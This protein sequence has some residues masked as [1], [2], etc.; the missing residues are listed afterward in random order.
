MGDT[1][2]RRARRLPRLFVFTVQRLRESLE[3][4]KAEH[5]QRLQEIA[6]AIGAL[7]EHPEVLGVLEKLSK[8]GY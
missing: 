8:L 6:E 3:L 1:E 5:E 4:Q 7:D 2:E